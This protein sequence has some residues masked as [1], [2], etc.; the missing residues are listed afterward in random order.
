MAIIIVTK[1]LLEKNIKMHVL[2]VSLVLKIVGYTI[3][4]PGLFIL[5]TMCE[6]EKV[7]NTR[8]VHTPTHHEHVIEN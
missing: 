5:L 3:I 2:W 1:F 8:Q 7:P 6:I 4:Y